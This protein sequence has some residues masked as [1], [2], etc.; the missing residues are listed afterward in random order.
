MVTYQYHIEYICCRFV[1]PF[2]AHK[3]EEDQS[4]HVLLGK[5][6]H[7]SIGSV[8]SKVGDNVVGSEV[9]MVGS[10]VEMVGSSVATVGMEVKVGGL[11]LEPLD[12]AVGSTVGEYVGV[13]SE[14]GE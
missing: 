8:G 5:E 1:I 2:H 6:T 3:H 11:V 4:K 13:G 9:E 12:S 7:L 10:E 14:V